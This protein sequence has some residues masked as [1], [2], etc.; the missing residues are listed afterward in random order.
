MYLQQFVAE[1][2]KNSKNVGIV[3]CRQYWI[4]TFENALGCEQVSDLNLLW[5][6]SGAEVDNKPNFNSYKQ[7]GGWQKP[8]AKLYSSKYMCG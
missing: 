3:G 4:P 8:N 5:V 2:K 1:I 6:P 7:I